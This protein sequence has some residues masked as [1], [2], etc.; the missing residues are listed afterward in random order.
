MAKQY[1]TEKQM[2]DSLGVSTMALW[3]Y[4]RKGLPFIRLDGRT[5]RFDPDDVDAWLKT[6]WSNLPAV[7]PP[8]VPKSAP[9]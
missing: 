1:L 8:P 3:R 6:N 5:L 4:R 7:A 2:A 9:P